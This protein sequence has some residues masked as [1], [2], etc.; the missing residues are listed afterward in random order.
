MT[1]DLQS[2]EWG[3]NFAVLTT[4]AISGL[5][6]LYEVFR[7]RVTLSTEGIAVRGWYGKERHVLW[8]DIKSIENDVAG[9]KFVIKTLTTKLSVGHNL[10]G[11]DWFASDCRR[12]LE[13]EVYGDAFEKPLNRYLGF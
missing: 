2:D 11:Q 12:S 9:S 5:C 1:G 10:E 3:L 6:L 8:T 7:R 4:F 13:P